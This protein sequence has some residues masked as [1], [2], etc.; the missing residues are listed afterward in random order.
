LHPKKDDAVM[1]ANLDASGVKTPSAPELF[2][3]AEAA[4]YKSFPNKTPLPRN[5]GVKTLC[6][7]MVRHD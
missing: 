7:P 4:P 6:S 3:A 5:A 1:N 2:G